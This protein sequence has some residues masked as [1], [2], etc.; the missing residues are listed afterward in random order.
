MK[1][2]P[3]FASSSWQKDI[4][5]NDERSIVQSALAQ[6]DGARESGFLELTLGA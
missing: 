3:S 1:S 6:P 2:G 4:D 5:G